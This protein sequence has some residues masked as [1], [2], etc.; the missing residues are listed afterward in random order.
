[1]QVR[2]V[3]VSENCHGA[4][5]EDLSGLRDGMKEEKEGDRERER[6]GEIS[7]L[8]F[9]ECRKKD[10]WKDRPLIISLLVLLFCLFLLRS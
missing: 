6:K 2:S 8:N 4:S 5:F 1:M 9:E 10:G 7:S 3:T